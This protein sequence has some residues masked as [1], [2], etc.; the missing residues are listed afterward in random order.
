MNN[1]IP[2]H[3]HS[4]FS[5]LDGLS[6]PKDIAKRIV[7]LGLPGCAITDHGS[8]SGTAEFMKEM[9][10][11]GKRAILGCELYISEQDAEIQSKDNKTCHMVVLA[12][13]LEG[14]KK[15]VR[16]TSESNHPNLFYRKPRINAER[17]NKYK[18]DDLIAFSGHMGSELANV[19]FIDPKIAFNTRLTAEQI[20][21]MLL[22]DWKKR[23]SEAADKLANIFGRKNFYVEIQLMDSVI[24][25]AQ[26]VISDCLRQV[27]KDLS[28]KCLATP[29]AHYCR[30][31]D[32]IDQRIILCS[33]L[34]TTLGAVNQRLD[35]ADDVTM[36]TFFKS[37][38]YHIPSY[39]EL[40]DIHEGDELK[41]TLEVYEQCSN[42]SILRNPILPKV[43]C[44]NGMNADEYLRQLC[45]DGWAKK[46]AH[47]LKDKQK[48]GIYVD[49][50]KYE[51]EVLQG[52]GLSP[53]FLIVVDIMNY[54]RNNGCMPGP[55]RGSAAGCLVS[56]LTNI[57]S[58]DP[59]KY[60]LMFERF[61]NAGRNTKDRISMPD[62][63][64]DMPTAIKDTV[65]DYIKNK[66]GQNRV[67]Q[68]VSFQTMKG[69][70]S[71]K[72]VL[73]A[74]GGISNDLMNLITKPI[75]DEAKIADELQEMKDETGESS[76]IRW[77][78]ENNGEKLK[79][80]CSID[81]ENNLVGPLAKRFEQAIRLEGTKRGKS[82]HPA[83]VIIAPCDLEDICPMILDTESKNMISAYDMYSAEEA[84][85]LKFDA[86]GVNG[87][88]KLMTIQKIAAGANYDD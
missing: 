55:G 68:M 12:K 73:R 41:N 47:K 32:A 87:L 44:P 76:I 3:C 18:G 71:I 64:M 52:A 56:Y 72:D 59:I 49:R 80:W 40:K 58:I 79:E 31:E 35:N 6:K 57:T 86:L 9:N 1:Y 67:C 74:Y 13:N 88:D 29:D 42:Y 36:G 82:R 30:K 78:L 34:Q 23:A 7:E 4:H 54:V 27:A 84:G 21:G 24:S 10:K 22:P 25:P 48:Q 85:L 26:I 19:L 81:K 8:L 17:I 62:I 38:C 53:Y 2:L 20:R 63:D 70:S 61:Y 51:L 75:P 5:L 16:L 83:G 15:L 37:D 66:H 69:R 39:D 45:R 33:A 46:I 11:V 14:W 43:E 50:I 77:T 28:L 60:D 65:F